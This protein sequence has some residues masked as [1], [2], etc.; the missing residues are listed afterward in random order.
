[1]LL[2]V[3]CNGDMSAT[4]DDDIALSAVLSDAALTGP[5][6][7]VVAAADLG[8][9]IRSIQYSLD[10]GATWQAASTDT[11]H[12]IYVPAGQILGLSAVEAGLGD[13]VADSPVWN[14]CGNNNVGSVVSPSAAP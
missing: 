14:G 5:E 4:A 9:W 3:T 8:Q 11:N 7:V 6:D 13:W 2:Q 12:P 10:Q 1:M